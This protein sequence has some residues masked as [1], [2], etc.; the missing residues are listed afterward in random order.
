[1]RTSEIMPQRT[2]HLAG[3]QRRFIALRLHAGDHICHVLGQRLSLVVSIVRMWGRGAK[4]MAPRPTNE[5]NRNTTYNSA[6]INVQKI[7][8]AGSCRFG[9]LF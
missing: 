5:E 1:M 6:T 9:V 7:D 4:Y 8:H 3:T 2:P